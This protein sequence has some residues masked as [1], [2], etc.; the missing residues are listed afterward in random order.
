MTY[1]LAVLRLA[2]APNENMFFQQPVLKPN[3]KSPGGLLICPAPWRGLSVNKSSI[4][5]A[6]LANHT[7]GMGLLNDGFP[8]FSGYTARVLVV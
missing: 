8:F 6:A 2:R 5:D 7:L 4:G 1:L 3:I